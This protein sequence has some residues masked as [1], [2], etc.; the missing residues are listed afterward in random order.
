MALCSN[1][2]RRLDRF[3]PTVKLEG[4]FLAP[5]V[6][7]AWLEGRA[8]VLRVTRNLVFAAGLIAADGTAVL[9]ASAILKLPAESD[10]RFNLLDPFAEG[11]AGAP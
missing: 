10:P 2:E 7:G 6:P 4:D 8:Q 1:Y 11:G 5:A 3:L 9:R